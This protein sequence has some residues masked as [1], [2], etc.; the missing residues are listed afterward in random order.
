M[1]V[2]AAMGDNIPSV[3]SRLN[4][5]ENTWK[6]KKKSKFVFIYYLRDSILNVLFSPSGRQN[7]LRQLIGTVVDAVVF[8]TFTIPLDNGV[9]ESIQNSKRTNSDYVAGERSLF[10]YNLYVLH[11]YDTHIYQ[12]YMCKSENGNLLW[13]G[14]ET[15]YPMGFFFFFFKIK[16]NI[17]ERVVGIHLV[18]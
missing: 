12:I 14:T 13:A 18:Q 17:A 2:N 5:S 4:G 7:Q 10:R 1:R 9:T 3:I 15:P 11:T 6:K 16:E 8:E